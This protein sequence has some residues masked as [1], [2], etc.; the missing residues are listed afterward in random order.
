M[1]K[2]TVRITGTA[3]VWA[4]VEV[5]A[6]SPEKAIENIGDTDPANSANWQ[7]SE[8]GNGVDDWSATGEVYDAAGE[9]VLSAWE[10]RDNA[11]QV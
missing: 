2:Y 9:E 8:G 5:E 3:V 1:A 7:F 4:D 6:D 10:E 11:A